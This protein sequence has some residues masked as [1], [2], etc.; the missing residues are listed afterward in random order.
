VA[1]ISTA[2]V[3]RA[4]H[5]WA[6]E[7]FIDPAGALHVFLAISSDAQGRHFRIYETHPLDA[8]RLS[9]WSTPAPITGPG[10][11]AD[12]IDPFVLWDGGVYYL[13]WKDDSGLN[14]GVSASADL[15]SGYRLL[16]GAVTP[17]G[18]NCEGPSVIPVADDAWR[19]ICDQRVDQGLRKADAADHFTRW[20]PFTPLL[21]G[22]GR[23]WNHGTAVRVTDPEAIDSI[24]VANARQMPGAAP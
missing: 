1:D 7:L 4:V 24:R 2:A 22:S 12:A 20:M 15:T 8:E 9:A 23:P 17:P 3:P 19:L 16:N 13:F 11:P 18:A 21:N 14:L 6:P 5:N 10:L